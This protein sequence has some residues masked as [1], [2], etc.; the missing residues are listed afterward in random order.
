[1]T[2]EEPDRGN[3]PRELALWRVFDR[4]PFE[5]GIAFIN[6]PAAVQRV[7]VVS[8]P[9]AICDDLHLWECALP[10]AAAREHGRLPA[11]LTGPP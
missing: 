9:F 5:D 8:L 4:T 2:P 10:D 6:G 7:V 1:M 11:R 3:D